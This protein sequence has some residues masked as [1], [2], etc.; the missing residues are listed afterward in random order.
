MRHHILVIIAI[1]I[2]AAPRY[3]I[4]PTS[5]LPGL[6]RPILA[7]PCMPYRGRARSSEG[8]WMAALD[9]CW[10]D[11]WMHG[12]DGWMHGCA[13]MHGRM[14]GGGMKRDGWMHGCMDA[15]MDGRLDGWRD[16]EGRGY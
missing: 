15:W 8:G 2:V 6:F 3:I 9:G 10:M 12:M 4:L 5:A 16:E 11:V 1:M 13:W 14:D 7:Q